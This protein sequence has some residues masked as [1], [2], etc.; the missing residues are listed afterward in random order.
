MIRARSAEFPRKAV[1]RGTAE[2]GGGGAGE[3]FDPFAPASTEPSFA[4]PP[5]T[6]SPS[7]AARGRNLAAAF[8][9]GLS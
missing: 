5:A 1:R 2:G 7:P 3:T 9:G 4:P 6:R 8:L